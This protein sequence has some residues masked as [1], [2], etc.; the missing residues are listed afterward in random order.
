MHESANK[1]KIRQQR[2]IQ[3]GDCWF[4]LGGE[5]EPEGEEE[6]V[7]EEELEQEQ[8]QEEEL[9]EEQVQEEVRA[10]PEDRYRRL[11][12]IFYFFQLEN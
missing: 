11:F 9:E 3:R 7:Q 4:V 6:Q 10:Y 2:G 1:R 8:V 12:L 5:G